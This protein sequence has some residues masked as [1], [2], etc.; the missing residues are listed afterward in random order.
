VAHLLDLAPVAVRGAA[1]KQ[2]E[3]LKKPSKTVGEYFK[4]LDH[5]N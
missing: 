2:R 5:R 4:S 3:S 1:K